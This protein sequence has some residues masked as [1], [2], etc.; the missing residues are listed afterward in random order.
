MMI[1]HCDPSARRRDLTAS[2]ARMMAWLEAEAQ[3]RGYVLSA[4]YEAARE[5]V[6]GALR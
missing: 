2:L 1:D 5:Y 3:R 6:R 4:E